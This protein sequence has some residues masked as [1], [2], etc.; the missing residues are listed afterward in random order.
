MPKF[1]EAQLEEAI[2]ELFQEQGYDYVN[3]DKLHRKYD[4]ILLEED[5]RDFLSHRYSNL[6]DTELEKVINKIK[7]VPNTPLYMGNREAF[8]LVNEG[9]NLV[10]DD[11]ALAPIHIEYIDFVTG[12]I[13]KGTI[14]KSDAILENVYNEITSNKEC[15]LYRQLFEKPL[16][17]VEFKD[18]MRSSIEEMDS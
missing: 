13:D 18:R 3:G 12:S 11:S 5:M 8:Y 2:I 9:F 17:L 10:R 6:T 1:T 15:A 7:Y 16:T 4:D 14:I